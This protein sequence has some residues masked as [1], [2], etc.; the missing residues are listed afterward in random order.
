MSWTP[1]GLQARLDKIEPQTTD[2]ILLKIIAQ[3]LIGISNQLLDIVQQPVQEPIQVDN[4][5]HELCSNCG[6]T[7]GHRYDCVGDLTQRPLIQN[8]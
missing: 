8:N 3:A 6:F 1:T 7:G 4:R 5:A 2:T